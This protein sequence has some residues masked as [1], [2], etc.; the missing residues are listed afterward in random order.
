MVHTYTY[1]CMFAYMG[2]HECMHRMYMY[3]V[4]HVYVEIYVHMHTSNVVK[5]FT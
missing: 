3:R 1:T 2:I 4:I 5:Q